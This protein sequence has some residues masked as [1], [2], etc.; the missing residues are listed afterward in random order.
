MK[1][2]REAALPDLLL[3][4]SSGKHLRLP[5]PAPPREKATAREDQAGYSATDDWPRDHGQ[6]PDLG[7]IGKRASGHSVRVGIEGKNLPATTTQPRVTGAIEDA[8]D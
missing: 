6:S 5:L 2:R 7:T 1:D 8:I 4:A 3:V